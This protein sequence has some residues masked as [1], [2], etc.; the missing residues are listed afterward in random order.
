MKTH[1]IEKVKYKGIVY[2]VGR[3]VTSID[4]KDSKIT[5]LDYIGNGVC[6]VDMVN[7]CR[8]IISN[9]EIWMTK[10]AESV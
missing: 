6:S 4:G 10:K 5:A 2:A 3:L 9:A 7:G 1:K 8:L